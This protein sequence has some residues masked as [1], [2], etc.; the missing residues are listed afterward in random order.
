VVI[1]VIDKPPTKDTTKAKPPVVIVKPDSVKAK[2]VSKTG[3]PAH[4]DTALKYVG[5]SE[6][7]NRGPFFDQI[8]RFAK[9][10]LGSP[11]CASFVTW[12][13]WHSDEVAGPLIKTAYSRAYIIAG[14]YKANDVS[15]RKKKPLLGDIVIWVRKNGGHVGFVMSWDGTKGKTLEANTSSGSSGSQHDGGGIYRRSRAIEPANF[16]RITHFTVVKYK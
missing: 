13:L 14:S 10:A 9:T 11:Y 8:N 3:N 12:C 7:N 1:P 6:S 4:I 16:F 15:L 2:P 5:L